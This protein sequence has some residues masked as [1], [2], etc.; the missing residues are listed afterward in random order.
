MG[1]YPFKNFELPNNYLSEKCAHGY[2]YVVV[3]DE[4]SEESGPRISK[5]D[6]QR[7]SYLHG[8]ECRGEL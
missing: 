6:C 3:I 1:S 4:C 2:M 8:A 5:A 7:R